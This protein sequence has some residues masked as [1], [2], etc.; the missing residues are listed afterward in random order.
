MAAR[1][2]M[3]LT[4]RAIDRLRPRGREYTV[5]DSRVSGL[6][7][8]VRPSGGRSW[9]L[10]EEAGGCSR[11]VSLGPVSLKTVAE[12]RRVCHARKAEPDT[13]DA[14]ARVAPLFRDFVAGAWMEAH[15][16]GYMPSTR[17]C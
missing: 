16:D 6:G 2:R 12:A 3:R 5:W 11:R 13:T 10:L 15:F 9:V 7:V 8:R 17:A 4:D 1:Q 14:P